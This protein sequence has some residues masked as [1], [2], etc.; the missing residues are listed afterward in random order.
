VFMSKGPL[1]ALEP[2][3]GSALVVKDV[4]E[5]LLIPILYRYC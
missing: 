4:I 3:A 1:D 2:G 5:N